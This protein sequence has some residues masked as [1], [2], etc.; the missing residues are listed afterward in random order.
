MIDAGLPDHTEIVMFVPSRDRTGAPFDSAPWV[1][2][3][4]AFLTTAFGGAHAMSVDG[5]WRAPD[6]EM[7]REE[8]SRLIS[9]GHVLDVDQALPGLLDL[10]ARFGVETNQEEVLLVV[11][12]HPEFLSHDDLRN[13]R[14]VAGTRGTERLRSDIH[15]A[16][17][18]A[19]PV[20]AR[21]AFRLMTALRSHQARPRPS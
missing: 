6:G 4:A 5:Y 11:N 7:V 19:D 13:W 9:Y 15:R 18:P 16:R 10:A 3:I 21:G 20:D 2:R 8:T 12:G 17:G 1:E 14:S